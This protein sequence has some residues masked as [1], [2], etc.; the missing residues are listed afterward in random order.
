MCDKGDPGGIQVQP[1]GDLSIGH[2]ED[3]PHPGCVL[4]HRPQGVAQLL[5]PEEGQ[6]SLELP[7]KVISSHPYFIVLEPVVG[8]NV[9]FDLI[10][11]NILEEIT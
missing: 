8:N 5:G 6:G 11:C 4:F 10:L 7:N 9:T 1:R 3:L 2:D